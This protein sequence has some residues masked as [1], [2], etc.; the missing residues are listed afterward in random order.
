MRKIGF[1]FVLWGIGSSLWSQVILD[2]RGYRYQE[3]VPWLVHSN[4][5]FQALYIDT[6]LKGYRGRFSPTEAVYDFEDVGEKKQRGSRETFLGSREEFDEL[7]RYVRDKK[8]SLYAR[9]RLFEQAEGFLTNVWEVSDFYPDYTVA[10]ERPQAHRKL[11]KIVERLQKLPVDVWVVDITG[12]PLAYQKKA[13]QWVKQ[14]FSKALVMA[15]DE[16]IST[17]SASDFWRWQRTM[18]EKNLPLVPSLGF[19]GV[20]WIAEENVSSAGVFYYFFARQKKRSVMIS[21]AMVG[22]C[23]MI[24]RVSPS[25]WEDVR[26]VYLAPDHLWGISSRGVVS[27]YGGDAVRFTNYSIEGRGN[28]SLVFG[29]SYLRTFQKNVEGLFLPWSVSLWVVEK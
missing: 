1:F 23:T 4:L 21:P 12:L 19:S 18:M 5:V 20:L 9:V 8:L 13:S 2:M 15:D 24:E 14:N 16:S 29:S 25:Q 7:V 27:F 6:P 28:L 3:I 26:F 10:F 17:L 22:I 11:Q